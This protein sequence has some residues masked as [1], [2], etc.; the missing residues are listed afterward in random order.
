MRRFLQGSVCL[1]SASVS[2]YISGVNDVANSIQDDACARLA[3]HRPRVG[4]A[5]RL[6]PGG[7]S[8]QHQERRLADVYG[9]L[10]RQ[11]VFAARRKS[12]PSNFSK[13]EVAWR[14]KTDN[15]GA[16]PEFKLEGTPLVVKGVLY[17]TA[18]TRRSV[19]ALDA[20]TGELMWTYS[21]REGRRAGVAPRQ[22]SG[23]GV[24]YWTDGKGDERVLFVTTGYRL[25]AL[26]AKTGQPVPGF[27]KQGIVDLKEGVVYG[28]GTQIDLETGEIGL[29]STP[30]VANDMVLVGIVLQGRHDGR[31]LEQYEGAGPRL[32]RAH[33][34]DD[35]ALQHDSEARR[36][37]RRNLGERTR[38]RSTA[39][40]ASGPRSRST[41]RPASS[42]CRSS[43]R[44]LISTAASARATTC[45]GEIAG[46][47][48]PEDR[49]AQVALPVRAPCRLGSRHV[50]RA[51]ADGRDD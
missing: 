35:L 27:G 16:R 28:T 43:R 45:I 36:V 48:R 38:G 20:K 21:L 26:N 33:R 3:R 23:R 41:P 7:G 50:V 40:P 37:R 2:S 9:R 30:T 25:V 4:G 18:G 32:R 14:F 47:G 49:R 5:A 42:I 29:H 51:A 17:T 22:L 15:L 11:Q 24:A 39:T 6:R 12:M 10:A 31:D 44:P 34:Q 13:L 46:G 19:V 8:A 1:N